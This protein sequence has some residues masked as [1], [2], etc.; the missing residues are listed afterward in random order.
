[1]VLARHESKTSPPLFL[2]FGPPNGSP[3]FG[4]CVAAVP[5]G[6]CRA[7][8]GA[9]FTLV[10]LAVNHSQNGQ[11]L[12]AVAIRLRSRENNMA[13]KIKKFDAIRRYFG[14]GESGRPVT[15]D[16]LK[17]LSTEERNYLGAE[18]AR[19]LGLELETATA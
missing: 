13:E 19:M 9:P 15:M 1:M 10:W 8:R 6:L 2:A 4:R 18:S 17:A 14:E 5:L 7:L 16:E 11:F 12:D 3:T